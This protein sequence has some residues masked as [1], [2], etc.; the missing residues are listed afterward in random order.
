M[1]AARSPRRTPPLEDVNLIGC[2]LMLD[3]LHA[4]HDT[5]RDIVAS[6]GVDYVLAV[7]ANCSGTF[8]QLAAIDWDA[9]STPTTR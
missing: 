1:R 8:A 6:G 2:V 5:T 4:T 7:K 9:A 3:A